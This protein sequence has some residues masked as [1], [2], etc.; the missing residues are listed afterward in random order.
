M[1]KFTLDSIDI[2]YKFNIDLEKW[3][4]VASEND[5]F[6]AYKLYGST[7]HEYEGHIYNHGKDDVMVAN[8]MDFYR[9]LD[10]ERG[11]PGQKGGNIA[12]HFSTKTPFPFHFRIYNASNEL[13]IKSMFFRLLDAWQRYQ[14]GSE[15]SYYDC[16]SC[17][18][19]IV[20]F[21][22]D[23]EECPNINTDRISYAKDYI[24]GHFFDSSLSV[25]QIAELSGLSSRRFGD[26]FKEQYALSPGKYLCIKRIREA[27][28]LLKNTD[29]P[30]YKIAQRVGFSNANSFIRTFKAEYDISPQKYRSKTYL[31]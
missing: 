7:Q 22:T 23:K 28:Y 2:V 11:K 16:L 1:W 18:Y 5:H 6:I 31:K 27:E 29:E 9:V 15:S 8:G 12:V 3:D 10:N 30:I 19:S 14:D 24:D 13:H 21:I 25:S 26:L 17:F 20:A 4:R